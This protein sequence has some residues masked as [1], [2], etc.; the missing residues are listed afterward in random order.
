MAGANEEHGPLGRHAP[1]RTPVEPALLRR[2]RR[3]KLLETRRFGAF[4]AVKRIAAGDAGAAGGRLGGRRRGRGGPR[5]GL[6]GRPGGAGGAAGGPCGAGAGGG[7]EPLDGPS[8]V[9]PS[10]SR[11][12]GHFSV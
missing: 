11:N 12:G 7:P 8:S 4:L 9:P 10:G 2:F 1:A 5:R 3:P 6:R